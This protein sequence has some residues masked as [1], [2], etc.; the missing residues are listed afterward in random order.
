[1]TL[2][3]H[4]TERGWSQAELAERAGVSRQLVSAVESGR[5][6]P[7]VGAAL[8][9]ARALDVAVETLFVADEPQ[10]AAVAAVGKR[11]PAGPVRAG[12]VRGRAVVAPV[13]RRR[14][15]Y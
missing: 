1:M 13:A 8:A 6:E 14:G 2:R 3:Q 12:L 5:H 7:G 9:L 11:M 4:R 15:I 10:R